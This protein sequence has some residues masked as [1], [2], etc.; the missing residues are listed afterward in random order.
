VTLSQILA[1][2]EAHRR[3]MTVYAPEPLPGLAEH[4]AAP[5]VDVVWERTPA[6][7]GP[8]HVVVSADGEELGRV[9]LQ[10]VQQLVSPEEP[11]TPGEGAVAD[12][13]LRELLELVREATFSSFDRRQL[14]ATAREFEDR[15]VRVGDGALHTGFQDPTALDA[16][17]DLYASLA[18]DSD[19]DVH[20]YLDADWETPDVGGATVHAG[21][22]SELGEYWFVMFDGGPETGSACGLLAE[23]REDGYYGFWTYDPTTVNR[24]LTYLQ[25]TY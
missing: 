21:H 15:A 13:P 24:V 4:F 11:P 3:T 14:L 5:G 23:A 18:A 7:E 25:D 1:A 17:A 22:A 6:T 12:R 9:G 10:A 2:H 19:L 20:V 16:Q 8:G